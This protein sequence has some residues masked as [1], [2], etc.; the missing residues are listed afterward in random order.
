MTKLRSELKRRRTI[1]K[2]NQKLK[3]FNPFP[4]IRFQPLKSKKRW[5]MKKKRLS[6][7]QRARNSTRMEV[8]NHTVTVLETL[9]LV[10]I[11]KH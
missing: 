11:V 1:K 6:K 9:K 2:K 10:M 5:K 7:N 8:Y 3:K 4:R